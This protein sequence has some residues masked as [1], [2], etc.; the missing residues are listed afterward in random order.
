PPRD[1]IPPRLRPIAFRR[2][3]ANSITVRD[4]V[5][6]RLLRIYALRVSERFGWHWWPF[7]G[8]SARNRPLSNP[9]DRTWTLMGA[10]SP[11]PF[12]PLVT[13]LARGHEPGHARETVQPTRGGRRA[14]MGGGPLDV[15]CPLRASV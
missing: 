2:Q 12:P 4:R 11:N 13:T 1:P 6:P 14:M 15:E 8:F 5:P 10:L 3:F 7:A 9:G